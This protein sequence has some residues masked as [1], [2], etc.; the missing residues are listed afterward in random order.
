LVFGRRRRFVIH[1]NGRAFSGDI[2]AFA[3]R[4]RWPWLLAPLLLAF[5][6]CQQRNTA[7]APSA[8]QDTSRMWVFAQINV[9]EEKGGLESYYY[10]GEVSRALYKQIAAN[11]VQRGFLAL[12]NVRYWGTDDKIHSYRDGEYTGELVF[13]IED[14]KKIQPVRRA[15]MIGKGSEQWDEE[16]AAAQPAAAASTEK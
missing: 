14:V 15:P 3:I 7:D 16:S 6:G 1:Y 5:A 8:D 11:K 12:E 2:V 4:F 9:V 13:R 10:F